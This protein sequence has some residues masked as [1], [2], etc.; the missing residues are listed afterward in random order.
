MNCVFTAE[1][2]IFVQ[3]QSSADQH[4]NIAA[5]HFRY[6]FYFITDGTTSDLYALVPPLQPHQQKC[7]PVADS[8]CHDLLKLL[9]P[10]CN[11]GTDLKLRNI[12]ICM[13]RGREDGHYCLRAQPEDN[14]T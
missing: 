8:F 13:T 11:V 5:E 12:E 1:W 7:L 3:V 2:K 14:I 4:I 6:K 9:L 10:G